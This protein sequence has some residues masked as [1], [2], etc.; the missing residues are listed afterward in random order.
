MKKNIIVYLLTY[1][2][3]VCFLMICYNN[4]LITAYGYYGFKNYINTTS[5]LS[6]LVVLAFTFIIIYKQKTNTYSKFIVY[7]LLLINFV[8]SVITFFYMPFSF[9]YFFLLIVY[10]GM[11]ILYVN[12][13]NKLSI[14]DNQKRFKS[15]MINVYII[16]A[17]ELIVMVLI[18]R[19]T[20]I[21]L[22]V[23][24]VYDLR[25]NYFQMKIP[26]YLSYLYAA[27]KVVNPLLFV[28]L[29]NKRKKFFCSLTVAIQIVAFLADG[30]KSTL[31]SIFLAYIIIKYIQKKKIK[32]FLDNDKT[33]YYILLGVAAVNVIG[34][35]E[36]KLIKKS[37]LYN[38]FIRRTFFIPSLLNHYYYDFFSVNSFD[39]FRQSILGKLGFSSVYSVKIQNL[40]GQV[41]FSDPNMLANNGLFSDAY[42][43]LGSIGM[44][45]MPF[46]VCMALRFLDYCS[47]NI[48]SYYLIMVLI[49]VSYTFISSSFFTVL[50]TH[51]YILL[52]LIILIILPK[53]G[54]LGEKNE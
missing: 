11:M 38:Y 47:R 23:S 35:L 24:T 31:F 25:N 22:N 36:F 3:Y 53:D 14:K 19:Y 50:L 37:Y 27:F 17:I 16:V 43:N 12:F 18:V 34:F 40:I 39:Y 46:L 30:S 1:I 15:N 6:S 42:M 45:I 29:Y 49:L 21:N 8:P 41:Y 20:G 2:V 52:C 7:I 51:G 44:I 4:Y 33:K 13:F 28:Y 54:G 10:W 5:L 9:K 26:T 32:D 48:S